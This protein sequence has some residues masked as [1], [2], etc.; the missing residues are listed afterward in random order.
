MDSLPCATTVLIDRI[1]R[2]KKVVVPTK[3]Q[4]IFP[5]TNQ[6]T[7]ALQSSTF[8]GRTLLIENHLKRTFR[9]DQNPVAAASSS[10]F[11]GRWGNFG[12]CGRWRYLL[13]DGEES[14]KED[15]AFLAVGGTGDERL[16]SLAGFWSFSLED[17]ELLS[18]LWLSFSWFR[19]FE[20]IPT[21]HAC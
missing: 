20:C 10:S 19:L 4:T 5:S 16:S 9:R 17:V 2:E 14:G 8:Q 3:T 6:E 21:L 18:R 11:V 1:T 15:S 13:D 12:R 7:K